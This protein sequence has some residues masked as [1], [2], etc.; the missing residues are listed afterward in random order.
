MNRTDVVDVHGYRLAAPQ[1]AQWEHAMQAARRGDFMA[2]ANHMA[3]IVA[4]QSD[5]VPA[6]V[7][8]GYFLLA[9]DRYREA[10]EWALRAASHPVS[11]DV[12]LQIVRLLRR[13]EE[14]ERIQ[15]L[16][17]RVDWTQSGSA[18]L[19]AQVAGELGPIGLYKQAL[20]L[21]DRAETLDPSH[22]QV[23]YL[24][25]TILMVSGDVQGARES[26]RSAIEASPAVLAH[27]HWMLTMQPEPEPERAD[28]DI[29]DLRGKLGQV[30]PGTEDDAYL[31]FALHNV[32]HAAG[33]F[34]EAWQMLDRGCQV[35]R[36]LVPYDRQKQHELFDALQTMDLPDPG[37]TLG[38]SLAEGRSPRVIFIVGMHRSGTS[39]V[40]RVLAG[41]SDV[42]D[43]GESYVFTARMREA[44]DHF[45]PGVIDRTT[46][47]R[48]A[49]VD[50]AAVGE[51][52]REYARWRAEGKGWFTEKLPS[53]FLNLGFILR[54]MPD[55]LV[56]HMRRDPADTCFSNLRT[57]FSSAAPYS[58]D[59]GDLADYFLMYRKLM[60]HWH[61]AF[62]GR[63][64]DV[65]YQMFV[66]HPDAQARRVADFCGLPYEAEALDVSRHGGYSATAS[67]ASVRTGIL[68]N[69]GEAWKPYR[70]YLQPLFDGLQP[71]YVQAAPTGDRTRSPG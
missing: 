45:C 68:K 27:V 41:H 54:A 6:F 48:A 67:I 63:I 1:V 25:G 65:D 26:L 18:T 24:R 31:S 59:Q 12:A 23:T 15:E 58:Y 16:V 61:E 69:R 35:K 17:S 32:L 8:G 21:L 33:R 50:L 11:A 7:Q 42:A 14:P 3:T 70:E 28:R 4:A 44:V 5:F 10:R 47:A 60:R 37:E 66:E 57:F 71:A 53:N 40:E 13:F 62:P 22:P 9:A 38:E 43:G 52:F 30:A 2:A 51:R 39:V 64:L 34:D 19:L 56:L 36:R 49:T 46:V 55:A 20:Q 29:A